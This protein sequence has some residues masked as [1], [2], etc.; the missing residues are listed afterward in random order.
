MA[1]AKL[2]GKKTHEKNDEENKDK[3]ASREKSTSSGEDESK[4]NRE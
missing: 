1:I 4:K 3:N 2:F